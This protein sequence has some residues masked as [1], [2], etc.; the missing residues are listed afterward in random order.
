MALHARGHAQVA[1]LH[2]TSGSDTPTCSRPQEHSEGVPWGTLNP[3]CPHAALSC[4]GPQTWEV[5]ALSELAG[6]H[7]A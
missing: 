7:L 1:A 6:G 3:T 5:A 4:L 2:W